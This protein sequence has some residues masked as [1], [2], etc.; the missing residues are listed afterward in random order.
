MRHQ[1]LIVYVFVALFAMTIVLAQANKE[2][3]QFAD[4][5]Q[6]R[7][8]LNG[9]WVGKRYV[10]ASD[11]DPSLDSEE[12]LSAGKRASYLVGKRG[13]YLVGKR[14]SYLVGRKRRDLMANNNLQQ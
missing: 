14:A 4:L 8:H 6:K 10:L 9:Y 7:K 3:E 13:T 1:S 11:E 5:L 2:R 12:D